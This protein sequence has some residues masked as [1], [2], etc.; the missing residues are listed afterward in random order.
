[1]PNELKQAL[2]QVQKHTLD[3]MFANKIL[4]RETYYQHSNTLKAIFK[5]PDGNNFALLTITFRDLPPDNLREI[6]KI[7]LGVYNPSQLFTDIRDGSIE[8]KDVA[9]EGSEMYRDILTW[10]RYMREIERAMNVAKG[11][12][13]SQKEAN[14]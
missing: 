2:E 4:Y 8:S 11:R 5:Q 7:E 3:T 12:A 1:M 14:T 13:L 10:Y 9:V 6:D